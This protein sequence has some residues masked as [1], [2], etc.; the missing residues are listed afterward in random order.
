MT[1]WRRIRW[2]LLAAVPSSLMLGVTTYISTDLAAFPLIW[3]VPL[4]LY[5]LS[6][7]LVYLRWPIPWTGTDLRSLNTPHALIVYFGQPLLLLAL[8]WVLLRGGFGVADMFIAWIAFFAVA[9]ACHGELARDRPHPRYLTEYFLWMSV[10]GALGG[11][12]N[13]I[14]APALFSGVWE[15]Y[16]ALC[17][18]CY[19]RPVLL[20]ANWTENFLMN[21]F[22]GLR[23]SARDQSDQVSRSMGKEP[24]GGT[25]VLSYTL[26]ILLG[27]FAMAF[28]VWF[29]H[30]E[31]QW[32]FYNLDRA[33]KTLKFLGFK[34]VYAEHY[35][36]NAYYAFIYGIP[37]IVCG[38][39]SSR[40]LRFGLAITVLLSMTF[41]WYNAREN[42]IYQGRTY[43]GVLR[44][45]EDTDRIAGLT[46][47]RQLVPLIAPEEFSAFSEKKGG[48]KDAKPQYVYRYTYLMHGTTYHGRN[49]I[50]NPDEDQV[51]LSRLATTYY[52]R[53]GP[54]GA[55]ME[56]D[57]WLPGPQN[58]FW[59]DNRIP[60]STVGNILA[61]LGLGT[62][63]YHTLL[64]AAVSE[65]AYATIGLGTGTMASYCRPYQHLTFY[66]IDR[67]I[68]EFSLP[69]KGNPDLVRHG[70][71]SFF[72]Y[73][74]GAIRRGAN[75]EIVMGD[76]R[77]TME[78]Q[79][80]RR[81]AITILPSIRSCRATSDLAAKARTATLPRSPTAR[82]RRTASTITMRSKSM[83]L[84]R[85][86]SRCK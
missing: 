38:L 16:I 60:A 11:F 36:G 57:N 81:D 82:W 58:T 26:D 29:T 80:Q 13:A 42:V 10:G 37:L 6:F 73:L 12:L 1:W 44:V 56:R 53:Y 47:D 74:Q 27:G 14:I 50:Y 7:I 52:H 20:D 2:V 77:L 84:A 64:N 28:L 23:N 79:Q 34:D 33:Y 66:E 19:I 4:A 5:L 15:F 32:G 70:N 45:L 31:S 3:V 86:P 18:A 25:Y 85:T 17:V 69:P 78:H 30:A 83:R 40:P 55:V 63:P 46:A 67:Q 22:P 71:R 61:D 48:G 41:G 24:E 68:R 76:A 21:S 51:N 75:L 65:P 59:G 9:L 49:Y 54:V 43:F 72:T 39:Y 8:C 35:A 62:P